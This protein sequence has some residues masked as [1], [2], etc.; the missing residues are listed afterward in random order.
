MML[1]TCVIELFEVCGFF[2]PSI[3]ENYYQWMPPDEE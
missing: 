3:C 1:V 2:G